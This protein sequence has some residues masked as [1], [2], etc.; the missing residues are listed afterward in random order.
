M[1]AYEFKALVPFDKFVAPR[2]IITRVLPGHDSRIFSTVSADESETIPIQIHFSDIMNC[3]SVK[4]SLYINSTTQMGVTAEL[5]EDSITCVAVEADEPQ[6]VGGVPTTWIFRANIT[7]V[8]NGVHQFTVN[9]ATTNVT[10]ASTNSST[11]VGFYLK[12][13]VAHN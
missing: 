9:N 5:D 3:T 6:F 12:Q 10:F 7:N 8:Y 1:L 11:N 4:E 13:S 2:P